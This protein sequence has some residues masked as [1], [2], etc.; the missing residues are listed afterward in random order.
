MNKTL[1]TFT[2][3]TSNNFHR[4]SRKKKFQNEDENYTASLIK[5]SRVK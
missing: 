1:A 4:T 3:N 2:T 5:S